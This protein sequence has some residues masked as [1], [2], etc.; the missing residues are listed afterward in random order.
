[1][2]LLR[3]SRRPGARSRGSTGSA[4]VGEPAPAACD[5]SNPSCS[6]CLAALSRLMCRASLALS[7]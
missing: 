1:M 7:P 2:L 3:S 4:A 5:N 6:I